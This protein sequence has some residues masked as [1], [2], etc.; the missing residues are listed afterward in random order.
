ML[1][2]DGLRGVTVNHNST[3][4][5][6]E[7]LPTEMEQMFPRPSEVVVFSS[8]SRLPTDI[9]QYLADNGVKARVCNLQKPMGTYSR[10]MKSAEIFVLPLL[11]FYFQDPNINQVLCS[12]MAAY[13]YDVVTKGKKIVRG[14]IGEWRESDKILSIQN[15]KCTGTE[16]G[17]QTEIGSVWTNCYSPKEIADVLRS[18]Q[19][20]YQENKE[21]IMVMIV[22]A[23]IVGIAPLGGTDI[24]DLTDAEVLSRLQ[25][26]FQ[27]SIDEQGEKMQ[28]TIPLVR[29]FTPDSSSRTFQ[30]N[31]FLRVAIPTDL[32]DKIDRS[33]GRLGLVG[34]GDSEL[35]Y[36]IAIAITP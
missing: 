4:K 22:K 29:V 28:A 23:I 13:V 32:Y 30:E 2:G 12:L 21:D 24:S 18:S 35:F 8:I 25:K 19:E 11:I 33:V 9:I 1:S 17:V 7:L 26:F 31:F 34:P 15:Y 16:N 6:L 27:L 10:V 14:A 5:R 36:I 3:E 20:T